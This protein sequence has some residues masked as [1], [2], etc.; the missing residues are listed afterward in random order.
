MTNPAQSAAAEIV[1]TNVGLQFGAMTDIISRHYAP[2]VAM[3][4]ELEWSAWDN[5]MMSNCCP[6]CGGID[7]HVD[8]CRLA[9]LLKEID[10]G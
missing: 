6:E 9:A 1:D 5:W 4:R 7:S 10:N 8:N 3:L 2:L